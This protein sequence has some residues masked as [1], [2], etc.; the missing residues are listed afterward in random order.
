[1]SLCKDAMAGQQSATNI[2]N[3]EAREH[4]DRH[5]AYETADFPEIDA[6]HC[7]CRVRDEQVIQLRYLVSDQSRRT[8]DTQRRA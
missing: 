1:M 8:I 3:M 7:R 4:E 5:Y 2:R 6:L